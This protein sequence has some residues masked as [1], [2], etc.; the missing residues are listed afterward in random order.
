[1]LS[2]IPSFYG[3][4]FSVCLSSEEEFEEG[5]HSDVSEAYRTRRPVN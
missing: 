1:M 3:H 4:D 5:R 2:W